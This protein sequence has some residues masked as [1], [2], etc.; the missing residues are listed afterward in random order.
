[1]TAAYLVVFVSLSL[2]LPSFLANY[3]KTAANQDINVTA[4]KLLGLTR[5]EM[6]IKGMSC[7]TCPA[8]IRSLIMSKQ[9]VKDAQFSYP[10]GNGYVIFAPSKIS[11][12]E[13]VQA[14]REG[15][16]EAIVGRERGGGK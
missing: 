5:L 4:N 1:M 8:T 9:G 3:K 16:Y 14:L 11:K 2:A 12:E 6:T 7:P 13:I 15:G 10:D